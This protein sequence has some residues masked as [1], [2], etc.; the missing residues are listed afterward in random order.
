[1]KTGGAGRFVSAEDARMPG[2]AAV[3]RV[4]PAKLDTVVLG[5][6]RSCSAASQLVRRQCQ[7]Q[8]RQINPLVAI[9][10]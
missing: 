9:A 5:R 7:G 10:G 8:Y 2:A 6:R 3:A 4:A 1:M